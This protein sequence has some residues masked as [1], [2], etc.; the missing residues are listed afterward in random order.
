MLGKSPFTYLRAEV[1]NLRQAW[2]VSVL[3]TYEGNKSSVER[4]LHT[5]MCGP[6]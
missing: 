2:D 4:T 6:K 1:I 5:S 3:N